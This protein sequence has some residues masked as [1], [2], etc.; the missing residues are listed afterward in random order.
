MDTSFNTRASLN[1]LTQDAIAIADAA[2]SWFE[3]PGAALLVSLSPAKRLQ[4]GT[5]RLATTA[6]LMAAIAWLLHPA[7]GTAAMPLVNPP[8]DPPMGRSHPFENTP[9]GQIVA[10]SKALVQRLKEQP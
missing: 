1:A 7:Q 2:R 4:A 6:R 8:P 9:G 10:A 3:G 5:E